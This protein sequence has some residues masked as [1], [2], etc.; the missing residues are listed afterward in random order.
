MENA[1][2]SYA[3]PVG[4]R[5]TSAT[6][7]GDTYDLDFRPETAAGE[8]DDGSLLNLQV[9][10]CPLGKDLNWLQARVEHVI[11][12]NGGR[13]LFP[14]LGNRHGV[15]SAEYLYEWVNQGRKEWGFQVHFIL[16]GY[17]ITIQLSSVRPIEVGGQK[18]MTASAFAESIELGAR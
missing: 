7:Q 15:R 5:K 16:H 14:L 4:W 3:T 2:F 9:Y 10:P 1:L 18:M 17:C 6:R 13:I 8:V 12:Q 11:R